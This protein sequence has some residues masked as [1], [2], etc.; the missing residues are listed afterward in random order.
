MINRVVIVGGGTS[1]W[2]TATVLEKKCPNIQIVLI[3]KEVS[4][5]VG[6]GEA[7]LLGFDTFMNVH[8]GFDQNEWVPETDAVPKASILFPG[9]GSGVD[10]VWHPFYF[11]LA[12]HDV[13]LCDALSHVGEDVRNYLPLYDSALKN[14]V[15]LEN[16]QA[17]SW[18]IDATKLV[19]FFKRK[20]EENT[21]LVHIESEVVEVKHTADGEV[22]RLILEDG[23]YVDA[24]LF[25]DC[26]GFKSILKSKRDRVP[27]KGRLFVDTAVAGRISYQDIDKELKPYTTCT[28]VDHGWIWD[29]PLQ[30]RIGSG[31]V[32]NRQLTDPEEA[33]K[34]LCDFWDGRITPEDL[35]TIDWTPYYDR[36]QW[37][38]NVVSVG[39]S[40]GFIEPLES[41]GISLIIEGAN[42][43]AS[44]VRGRYF[45]QFD[46]NSFNTYMINMFE[47]CTDFVSMHYDLSTIQS[48]FWEYVRGTYQRSDQHNVY[49]D[50]MKSNIPSIINGKP[51]MFGGSNWIY[52]MMQMGYELTPKMTPDPLFARRSLEQY[53]EFKS[54]TPLNI[55]KLKDMKMNDLIVK[56]IP[57]F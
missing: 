15:D 38:K 6:V 48:P 3:D 5:P 28:A 33:K 21:S 4:T 16:Q 45:N 24:D 39:L 44:Y 2:L 17:Y 34:Y 57:I 30:S 23:T 13:P 43:L 52:W 41:T 10:Q 47:T 51:A 12:S 40:A 49:I 19:K 32:F 35:R 46:I 29:T 55:V 31:L 50:N 20:L 14:E 18:H 36:N 54:Q 42:Q 9:W 1:G 25:V 8:C 26:T 37:D 11:P 27:L 53:N 22:E 56:P 7:T